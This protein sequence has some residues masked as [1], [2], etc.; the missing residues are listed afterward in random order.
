MQTEIEQGAQRAVNPPVDPLVTGIHDRWGD[1]GM[2]GEPWPFM[3]ICSLGRLHSLVTKALE[4]EVKR[5]GLGRT[6]YFLLTT[7]ALTAEGR[8]RLSTLGRIL[9][10]HP[11]SVKLTV[12]QLETAG[13]VTRTPHPRDRRATYVHITEEGRERARAV[14]AALESP[15]GELAALGG[16]HRQVFEALQ[17]ARLAFDDHEL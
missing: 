11:T 9:M 17:P 16:L 4:N 10:M 3:A 8:A 12:D 15:D 14:N 13:L 2:P 1:Q 6:G 5:H 7:L